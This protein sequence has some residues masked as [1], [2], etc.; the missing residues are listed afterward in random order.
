MPIGGRGSSGCRNRPARLG[1]GDDTARLK[2]P[3]SA[4]EDCPEGCSLISLGRT[5]RGAD[6]V[7]AATVAMSLSSPEELELDW[8][9]KGSSE[10][11]LVRSNGSGLLME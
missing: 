7:M 6:A 2:V 3:R 4:L 9:P 5:I 8:A 11:D 10:N 1:N